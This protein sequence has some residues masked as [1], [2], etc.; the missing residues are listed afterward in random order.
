MDV[1]CLVAFGAR[2]SCLGLPRELSPA[3]VLERKRSALLKTLPLDFRKCADVDEPQSFVWPKTVQC[4][5][6]S[7]N[8]LKL[9]VRGERTCAAVQVEMKGIYRSRYFQSRQPD[10]TVDGVT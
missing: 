4:S 2:T 10:N 9:T 7:S 1:A 3:E 6:S 8:A 5:G